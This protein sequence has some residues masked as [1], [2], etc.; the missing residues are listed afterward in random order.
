M[1]NHSQQLLILGAILFLIGLLSGM[2]VEKMPNSR[3]GLAA[4]LEGVMNGMFL[5]VIGLSWEKLSLSNR[6][7]AI[8]FWLLAYGTFSNWVFIQAAAILRT[9]EMTPLAG[10]G[11][12]GE[13]WAES[14]ITGG[15][16]TVAISMISAAVFLVIGFYKYKNDK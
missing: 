16:T 12:K 2:V 8:T 7:K 13:P 4:H 6:N 1:K 10:A 9:S 14:L 11:F 15:L 5:I 3:M